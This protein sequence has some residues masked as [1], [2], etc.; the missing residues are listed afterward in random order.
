MCCLRRLDGIEKKGLVGQ[1]VKGV[2]G[3]YETKLCSLRRL[4]GIEKRGLAGQDVSGVFGP[5]G[6]DVRLAG[7]GVRC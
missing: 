4:E 3:S 7:Q 6:Q 5:Y 1:G 2:T